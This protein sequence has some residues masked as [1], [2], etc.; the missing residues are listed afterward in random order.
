MSRR[1]HEYS[2]YVLIKF[3][4]LP[5]DN[6]IS[7]L[8]R[9]NSLLPPV[10]PIGDSG[11]IKKIRSSHC[12]TMGLSASLEP[13]EAGLSHSSTHSGLRIRHCHSSGIGWPGELCMVQSGQ[14][15]KKLNCFYRRIC[16]K[17]CWHANRQGF[18][19]C[20][21]WVFFFSNRL[22]V[23]ITEGLS[24]IHTRKT[25]DQSNYTRQETIKLNFFSKLFTILQFKPY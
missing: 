11:Y 3:V 22:N 4:K 16:A 20:L 23:F 13:Q 2:Y 1:H 14:K 24:I 5:K 17:Y 25:C 10:L 8:F 18:F 21:F 12:G 7:K 6:P 19:V 9:R 15:S